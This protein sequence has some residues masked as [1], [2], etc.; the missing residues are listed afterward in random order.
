[1]V[2]RLGHKHYTEEEKAWMIRK[3][4]LPKYRQ[5]GGQRLKLTKLHRAFRRK[6]ESVHT[7]DGFGV[8]I[9]KYLGVSSK[10][11]P[12]H[13][14]MQNTLTLDVMEAK[15]RPINDM[16]NNIKSFMGV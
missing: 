11:R 15:L 2:A 14:R 1:M 7:L 13:K 16:I 5:K 8:S 3:A 4:A 6:F 12:Y 10:K 9:K